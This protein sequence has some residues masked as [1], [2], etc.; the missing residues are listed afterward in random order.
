V[1][2][3]KLNNLIEKI[4][5]ESE[6]Y[7]KL[8]HN[9][10][11]DFSHISRVHKLSKIIAENEKNVDMLI[12]E[13]AALL[14]DLG[15]HFERKNPE[16]NHADKSVEIAREILNKVGFPKEKIKQ[17]LYAI[18]VHRFNRGIIPS[19]IEA[20]ILQDADRVDISGAVGIAMTFTYGGSSEREIYDIKDPMA[21]KRIPDDKKYS[22]DHISNKLLK[23]PS[24]MNTKMG[25]RLAEKRKKFLEIYLEQFR[26][27][28]YQEN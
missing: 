3:K 17:V 26:N 10:G 13:T 16:I 21:K 14:H 22:L 19:T 18:E 23:L 5:R 9:S 4:K 8:N 12:L 28:I 11:H 1:K 15:R 20:K 2:Y 27:E 25:K 7:M 6:K 24:N